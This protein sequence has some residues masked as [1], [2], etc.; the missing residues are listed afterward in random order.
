MAVSLRR[1]AK[2]Q[3]GSTSAGSNPADCGVCYPC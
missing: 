1:L 2:N 3:M